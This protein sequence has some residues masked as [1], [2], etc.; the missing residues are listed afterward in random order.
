[1]HPSWHADG[2]YAVPFRTLAKNSAAGGNR[3]ISVRDGDAVDP[4]VPNTTGRASAGT[5]RCRRPIVSREG[6]L[7]Q[8]ALSRLSGVPRILASK[9]IRRPFWM[10]RPTGTPV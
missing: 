9:K 1:M 2:K 3:R 6:P 7:Q 8:S 10:I 5:N 4:D